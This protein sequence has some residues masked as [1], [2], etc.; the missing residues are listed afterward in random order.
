MLFTAI[1]IN[2]LLGILY[3]WSLFLSP[4]EAMLSESR[5]LLSVVPALGLLCFTLGVAFHGYLVR[6][7]PIRWLAPAAVALAGLGHLLFFLFPTYTGLLLGYGFVFGCSA[8]VGYG[9]ALAMAGQSAPAIR[10]WMVG[11]TVAAFAASGMIISIVGTIYKLPDDIARIFG[12]IGAL[13]LICAMFF[14]FLLR[15]ATLT[16][17]STQNLSG[18][19]KSTRLLPLLCLGVAYFSLCYPGLVFVGHG[20]TILH[21]LGCS[22]FIASLAPFILNAGYIVGALLGGV[23]PFYLPGKLAPLVLLLLTATCVGLLL[24]TLPP[25]IYIIAVFVIGAGLGSVVSVFFLVLNRQ[26]SADRS[27]ELFGR[28]NISYGL[29][30]I[31]APFVTGALYDLRES[32]SAALWFTFVVCLLG[33]IAIIPGVTKCSTS[34]QPVSHTNI[35]RKL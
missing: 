17:D 20:T 32:Y 27:R 4:L 31:S 33:L 11:V 22:F 18:E 21:T 30:G 29:A 25:L 24:M 19:E 7:I 16:S 28:L 26:Y 13:F 8:G 10:G 35:A 1:A 34:R 14:A 3:G 12:S 23:L 5:T 6:H 2:L 9:V 15:H